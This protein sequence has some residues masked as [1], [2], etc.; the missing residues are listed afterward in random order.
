MSKNVRENATHIE[1]TLGI[2]QNLGEGT[3]E[4]KEAKTTE[5][6]YADVAR[7]LTSVNAAVQN[8]QDP[9]DTLNVLKAALTA[10]NKRLMKN[11]VA[12]LS[13]LD[14]VDLYR[15]YIPNPFAKCKGARPD[16]N[17]GLYALVDV[18][19]YVPF[20]SLDAANP[21]RKITQVGAWQ[22]MVRILRYNMVLFA[23]RD[24]G[25]A[26]SN[27]SLTA[28]DFSFRKSI[29]W[30]KQ[31]SMNSL[32]SQ[33]TELVAAIL[34][35]ELC[36]K[37]MYKGDAK[38]LLHAI[39]PEAGV[40]HETRNVV[41]RESTFEQK[42]FAV[43]HTRME[44]GGY[45]FDDDAKEAAAKASAKNDGKVVSPTEEKPEQGATEAAQAESAEN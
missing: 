31:P 13:A 45:L 20:E 30:D 44:N 27:I 12:E 18:N 9:T 35:P 16:K 29:G 25:N 26:H 19:K 11:R 32:T 7:E 34:P 28:D 42:L 22:K 14:V 43:V 39:T 4:Q 21:T 15:E 2:T 1:P 6:L 36:P 5:Q 33:L 8:G 41:K 37:V 24:N 3:S 38:Q 40:G 23:V 17:T 10:L